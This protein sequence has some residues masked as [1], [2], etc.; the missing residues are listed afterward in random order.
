MNWT[1][2]QL[3]VDLPTCGFGFTDNIG[4]ARVRGG[5]M[6]I[7]TEVVAGMILGLSGSYLEAQ[8]TGSKPDVQYRTGDRLPYTPRYSSTIYAEYT[9]HA[10]GSM[11]GYLRAD[12]YR[13]GDA[14]R[15]PSILSTHANYNYPG[16]SAT[17][18]GLGLEDS[19]WEIRLFVNNVFNQMPTIDMRDVWGQ[20]R[21]SSLRPR[22]IGAKV[23]VRF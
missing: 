9:H 22:T 11:E 12:Y 23:G 15:E 19:R 5:E 1:D 17:N 10:F 18:L 4:T 13:R 3:S 6:E 16:W 7:D 8:I 20:W 14:V 21:T 2:I